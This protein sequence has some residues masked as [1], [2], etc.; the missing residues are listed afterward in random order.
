MEITTE[1]EAA[2]V[3]VGVGIENEKSFLFRILFYCVG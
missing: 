1:A 2:A 3:V